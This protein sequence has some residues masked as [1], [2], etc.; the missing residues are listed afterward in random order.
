MT[1]Q[2]KVYKEFICIDNMQN[3]R[4]L[5]IFV[6][7]LFA[8]LFLVQFAS[9]VAAQTPTTQPASSASNF[10][11]PVKDM[12]AKW[13]QG[14]LSVNIAKYLLWVLVALFVYSILDFLPFM[15]G[16]D[17]A[18]IR[19]T[20]SVVIGFL[21]IA[22]LNS[23]DVYTILASY[24]ALGFVLGAVA[25]F[26]ILLFGSIEVDRHGGIA[27]KVFVKIVWVA[28]IIFLVSKL[29]GGYNTGQVSGGNLIGYL[30]FLG[31]SIIWVLFAE[32]NFMHWFFNMETS[33]NMEALR[34][35]TRNQSAKR[36]I[37]SQDFENT[38]ESNNYF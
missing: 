23:S 15:K 6:L 16:R 29:I 27:G 25:P 33:S 18:W 34:V 3:K 8:S 31:I 4:V 20:V 13:Q 5:T 28:Y 24:S 38:G 17:K 37:E 12:F 22:F 35:Q 9:L 10:F 2:R 21:G 26:L 7:G 32:R 14:Q 11:D 1:Q 19:A 36:R 30:I